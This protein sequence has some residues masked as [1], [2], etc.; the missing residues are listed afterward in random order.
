MQKL[1]SF[2]LAISLSLATHAQDIFAV[3]EDGGSSTYYLV[4]IDPIAGTMNQIAP[5][6]GMTGLVI[7]GTSALNTKDSTY[8]FIGNSTSGIQLYE[9]D[10]NSGNVLNQNPLSQNIVGHQ[11]NCLDGSIY[12]LKENAGIYDF[13]TVDPSKGTVK[14]I[15]LLPGISAHLGGTFSLDVH[16]GIYTF[17][18]IH[19]SN[20]N[21][22]NIN[23]FTGDIKTSHSFPDNVVAQRYSCK[24]GLIYGLWENMSNGTYN[25]VKVDRDSSSYQLIDS[26]P[27]VIPGW[28]SESFTLHADSNWL[29]YLGYA[30]QQAL[31]T[32]DLTTGQI[33]DTSH[34]GFNAAGYE[35]LNCCEMEKPIA[36]FSASDTVICA[37][38]DT[39]NFTDLSTG[40]IIKWSWLLQGATPSASNKQHPDGIDYHSFGP[41]DVT[42]IVNTLYLADTL[43]RTGYIQSNNCVGIHEKQSSSLQVYPSLLRSGEKIF[44][45][46]K[47]QGAVTLYDM[48]GR[49][50]SSFQSG[51]RTSWV[52]PDKPGIYYLQLV[53]NHDIFTGKIVVY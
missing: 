22:V 9:V 11:F 49:I 17:Q 16:Q 1:L 3:W 4:R 26:L 8:S 21:L 2:F 32:I 6:P 39:V 28:I 33:V 20:I 24:T 48:Q 42:L 38:L 15:K 35:M 43:K 36:N 47:E 51:D 41:F 46:N 12:A 5:I 50:V 27:N 30:P 10:I 34:F 14:T 53:T 13:V 31:I 45:E 29:I 18:A 52:A 40:P 19:N 23:I 37:S 44:F 25:L 7:P